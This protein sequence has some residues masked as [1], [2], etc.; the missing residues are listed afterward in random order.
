MHHC[1][2]CGRV[3]PKIR[4]GRGDASRWRR[5]SEIAGWTVS[6]TILVLLPKCPVCVAAYVALI[7]GVGISVASA[8]KIRTGMVL[9]CLAILL[10]LAMR[11]LWRFAW[12]SSVLA[13][14]RVNIRR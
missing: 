10:C 5:A 11:Q 14:A 1:R 6:G 9:L 2:D 8:A 7:S 12:A 13:R 3:T 4:P